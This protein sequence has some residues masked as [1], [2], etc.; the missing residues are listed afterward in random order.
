MIKGIK[1]IST[2]GMSREDWLAERRKSIG[3]SDAAAVCGLSKWESPY[4]VWANK[5]G[6]TPEKE[7][8]E[9][10]RQGRDLEGYVAER[11]CEGTGLKV[12][13]ENAI[14]INP[15]Y[16]FAHANVDRMIVGEDAGLE[17]KFTS[18]LNIKRFKD[19]EFPEDYYVQCVHY[20]AVTGCLRWYLAVLVAGRAFYM[21]ELKRDEDEIKSLMDQE[22]EFWHGYV[23]T[24]TEPPIEG[25]EATAET[26]DAIYLSDAGGDCDLSLYESDLK[27]YLNLGEK[28]SNLKHEREEIANNIKLYMKDDRYG[29]STIAS[30][31]WTS[32]VRERFDV[33]SFK[34]DHPGVYSR[35][36]KT[37]PVRTFRISA[38]NSN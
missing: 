14:L 22:A 19:V 15:K 33:A 11:F 17:C 31:S 3:G 20:L 37:S 1:R 16:P 28:I 38:I 13:R 25:S 21:F 30:V 32:S 23:E 4:S 34:R 36:I 6:L 24:G 9:A 27:T 7:Q 2:V 26:I 10:M 29:F 35:Y 5:R 12:R 8:T 18:S